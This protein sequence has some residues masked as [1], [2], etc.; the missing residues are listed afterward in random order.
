VRR[1]QA[2]HP[3]QVWAIDFQFGARADGR[4]LKFLNVSDEHSCLCLAI[5]VDRRCKAK[6]VVAVL[7]EL[8]SLYPAPALIAGTTVRSSSL[9][10]YGTGARPTAKP[11]RPTSHRAPPGRTDSLSR[12][13]AASGMTYSTPSCSLQPLR[14]RSWLFVGA[15]GT[16]HS[17]RT[18]PSR[19]LR[20][21][22]HLDRELAHNHA[23]QLS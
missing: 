6:D 20:P 18:R 4:R 9:R 14:H 7:E 19:G 23:H 5:R 11:A 17:G 1:H 22:R 16:T 21:W 13:T 3:R 12:S 10:P 8:T 15:G 2:E